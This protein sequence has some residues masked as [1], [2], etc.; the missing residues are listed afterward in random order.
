MAPVFQDFLEGLGPGDLGGPVE[1]L[2][3]RGGVAGGGGDVAGAKA[4]RVGADF[5]G[6]AGEAEQVVQDVPY[7]AAGAGG[8]V[9][10]LAGGKRSSVGDG[11]G[12]GLADVADVE[13]VA[14]GVEIADLDGGGLEAGFDAG[15][16]AGEGRDGVDLGLAGAGVVEGAQANEA[17][18]VGGH[19]AEGEVGGGLGGGVG[20]AG[21]ERGALIRPARVERGAVGVGGGDEDHGAFGGRADGVSDVQRAVEVDAPSGVGV[22]LGFGGGGDGGEVE[23]G[24][25]VG[26]GDGVRRGGRVGDVEG[27]GEDT[28][29]GE[30]AMQ[31]RQQVGADEAG[32]SRY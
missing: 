29:V 9:E 25:G 17:E 26:G 30:A 15:D 24:L 12:V 3:G 23:H 2:A 14:D 21:G 32:A 18:A 4:G 1:R 27:G 7:P 22:A 16:L 8:D 19:G 6:D 31:D 13:K 10:D 28:A 11:G 5:G 20:V